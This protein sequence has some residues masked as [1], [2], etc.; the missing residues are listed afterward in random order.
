MK[1]L[2]MIGQSSED[3]NLTANKLIAKESNYLL[4]G[5]VLECE[6]NIASME[7]KL[8]ALE[9]RTPLNPMALAELD[10]DIDVEKALLKKHKARLRRLF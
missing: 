3:R 1:Y 6:K 10:I 2:E 4:Q 7:A 5:K 9:M 8:V